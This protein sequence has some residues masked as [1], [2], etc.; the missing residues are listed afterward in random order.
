MVN[1]DH[2]YKLVYLFIYLF[3]LLV[4]DVE[5]VAPPTLESVSERSSDHVVM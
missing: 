2:Y 1:K 4:G 3:Y 5:L